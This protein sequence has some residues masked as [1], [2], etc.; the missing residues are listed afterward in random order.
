MRQINCFFQHDWNRFF[1]LSV[2]TGSV[3]IFVTIFLTKTEFFVADQGKILKNIFAGKIQENEKF[4][5]KYEQTK[6][7]CFDIKF[8]HFYHRLT[9]NEFGSHHFDKKYE[10]ALGRNNLF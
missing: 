10:H 3:D 8:E 6:S 2:Y 4:L 1:I 7:K 5:E 9:G